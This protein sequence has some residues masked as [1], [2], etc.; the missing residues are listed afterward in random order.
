MLQKPGETSWGGAASPVRHH[1]G[2]RCNCRASSRLNH[3]GGVGYLQ[4]TSFSEDL[5]ELKTYLGW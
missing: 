5:E 1:Q 3:P 4:N 2:R